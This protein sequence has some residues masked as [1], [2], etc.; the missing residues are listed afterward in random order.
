MSL[1]RSP[2]PRPGGGWSSPGLSPGSGRS[3]P[4]NHNHNSLY[5]PLSPNQ[6]DPWLAARAKSD[7]VRGYPAFSTKNDGFFARS[8]R[9]ISATLTRFRARSK[10]PKGYG[11]KEHVVYGRERGLRSLW[12]GRV[13]PRRR[14]SRVLLVVLLVVFGYLL[15]P[16]RFPFVDFLT[17]L[18]A[19]TGV[20]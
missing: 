19:L 5:P 2:S 1:T 8:K 20:S 9:Q 3:T 6:T 12:A 7:E 15:W 11:E 17:I 18:V 4:R 10:S 16:C 13:I 14:R